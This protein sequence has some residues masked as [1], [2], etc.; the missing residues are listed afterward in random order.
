MTCPIC[1]E[2]ISFSD[3]GLLQCRHS[4]HRNCLCESFKIDIDARKF[5]IKCPNGECRIEC[6]SSDVVEFLPNDY[7]TKY[8]NYTF[9]RYVDMHN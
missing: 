2:E 7:V 5:P 6:I 4:F 3:L 9:E 8:E 1:L